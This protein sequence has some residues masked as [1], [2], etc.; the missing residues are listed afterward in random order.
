METLEYQTKENFALRLEVRVKNAELTRA[1]ESLGLSI[2]KAAEMMGVSYSALCGI[3]SLKRYPSQEI[4]Y[5]ICDFYRNNGYFM[6]KEDI[7]PYELSGIKARKMI[8]EKEIPKEKLISLSYI[9]QKLLPVYDTKEEGS[10][11]E[12]SEAIAKAVESLR[13]R[14]KMII[15]LRFG[16]DNGKPLTLKEVGKIMGLTQERIRQTEARALKNLRHP[17]RSRVLREFVSVE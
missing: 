12:L 6:L 9:N 4:Q 14:E 7:F 10:T 17:T 13:E 16:L 1:R 8:A 2:K 11:E 5:K 15:K 3:E